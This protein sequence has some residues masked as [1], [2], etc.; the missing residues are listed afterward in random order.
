MKKIDFKAAWQW[1]TKYVFN[2]YLLA[3]SVFAV[4]LLFV[5]D[6]SLL[7]IFKRGVETKN[8]ESELRE[9]LDNTSQIREDLRVFDSKDALERFAREKYHMHANDEDVYLIE[10]D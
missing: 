7:N 4:V 3:F 10:E 6:Q 9:I 8:K 1:C 5:G 2:V